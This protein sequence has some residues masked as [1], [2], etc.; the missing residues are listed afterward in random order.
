MKVLILLSAVWLLLTTII[1]EPALAQEATATPA[2]INLSPLIPT[3]P[4]PEVNEFATATPPPTPVSLVRIEARDFANV[5]AEPSTEAAQLGTIRAGETFTVIARYVSWIQF[6]YPAAP[7]GRGWVYGELVNVTGDLL[8]VPEIDPFAQQSAGS[9]AVSDSEATL[10]LLI[11]TPGGVLTATVQVGGLEALGSSADGQALTPM[12][13]FTYPPGLNAPVPTQVGDSIEPND[14]A[15]GIQASSGTP[16]IV[17]IVVLGGLGLL[18]LAI[19]SL[20]RS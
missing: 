5:R 7:N 12:P 8:A 16:P 18:G 3:T 9:N 14:G 13:T 2:I 10:A 20:R 19:G 15:E 17:P 11:Q 4:A 1:A 6:Q